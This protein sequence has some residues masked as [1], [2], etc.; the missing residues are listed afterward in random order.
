MNFRRL[1]VPLLVFTTGLLVD[2]LAIEVAKVELDLGRLD[3]AT[4]N[5]KQA[6]LEDRWLELSELL[7]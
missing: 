3:A 2:T 7:A 1:L 4:L 5:A 6:D